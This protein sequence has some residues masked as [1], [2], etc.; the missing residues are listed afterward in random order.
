MPAGKIL[1]SDG[2]A[3]FKTNTDLSCW[4]TAGD[5]KP[6]WR[7]AW[8]NEFDVDDFSQQMAMMAVNMGLPAGSQQDQRPNTP[9]EILLFG[10]QVQQ[11][12]SLVEGTIY[13]IEGRRMPRLGP[14]ENV[15]RQQKQF[16]WNST[17]RRA[18]VNWLAA[19]DARTGKARWHR[20]A[21]DQAKDGADGGV[22]FM[23]P[24]VACGTILLAP[25]TDGGAMWLVGLSPDDGR[26][27][28][29]TYLC[30]EPLG[31]CEAWSPMGVTVQGRDAYVLCGA[32]VVF[33]LDGTSGAIRWV[34]R[35]HRDEKTLSSSRMVRSGYGGGM[36]VKDFNGW[37]EDRL[38]ALGRQLVV[39][40]SDSDKLFA[41]DC[42]SGEFLW[43][44]PRT[45]PTG[46]TVNYCLGVKD[47]G[48]FVAG[49]N[50]VRRYDVPTGKFVWEKD[51]DAS[52]G[53]GAAYRRRALH[54][55]ERLR[56]EARLGKRNRAAASG[57][58]H[59]L[60][61][62]GRQSHHRW[63]E[64]VGAGRQPLLFAHPS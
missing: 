11:G 16:N 24:P 4:S 44:S 63:R 39:M 45:L 14:A 43:E 36:R 5:D 50:T 60:E 19:Y 20:A 26:T 17:P 47:R 6:L 37:A 12:M 51:V 52:L 34:V 61:R 35:Y 18:R 31:G 48:L 53:R 57:R 25:I 21:D 33:A 22:G 62:P 41:L 15:V 28:W 3:Y 42:R 9:A 10:D 29:K 2:R 7:S 55:C 40:A 13:N 27:L 38:V 49:K 32:G 58:A 56:V 59:H 1:I 30:D 46:P 64:A 54:S 8:L 23:A